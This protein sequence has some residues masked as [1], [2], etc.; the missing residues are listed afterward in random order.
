MSCWWGLL[1]FFESINMR[2][3]FLMG[4]WV[5][6][7]RRV[8]S[9]GDTHTLK[10]SN[11]CYAACIYQQLNYYSQVESLF[12]GL[13]WI[14]WSRITFSNLQ[15][16]LKFA[17]QA[18]GVY[19]CSCFPITSKQLLPTSLH[20]YGVRWQKPSFLYLPVRGKHHARIRGHFI[21]CRVR[22][23]DVILHGSVFQEP[24]TSLPSYV[25]RAQRHK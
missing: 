6:N 24:P 5:G 17:P 8:S 15:V 22:G 13:K 16:P 20:T 9:K 21:M 12:L 1:N 18:G 4:C 10:C 11:Q 25:R 14:A 7:T 19:S 23:T 3:S 2:I